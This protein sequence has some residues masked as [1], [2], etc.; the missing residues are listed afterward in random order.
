[1][2]F[3]SLADIIPLLE[4]LT[5]AK[6]ERDEARQWQIALEDTLKIAREERDKWKA[7]FD[8]VETGAVRLRR[9]LEEISEVLDCPYPCLPYRC[10]DNPGCTTMRPNW[11][12]GC[13]A[14]YYLKPVDG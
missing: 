10:C 6:R 12:A 9:G 2:S 1:M 5:A 3:P 11:C 8:A 4:E 13:I 7:R 14:R